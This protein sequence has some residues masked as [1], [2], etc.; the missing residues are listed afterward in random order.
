MSG[1]KIYNTMKSVGTGN[2]IMGILFIVAGVTGG[3]IM[4]VSGGNLLKK[5][6]EIL[7]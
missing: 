5:K 4:I 7:F 2:L 1:E 3:I 6:S